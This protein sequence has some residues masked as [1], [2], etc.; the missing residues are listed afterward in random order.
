MKYLYSFKMINS[1]CVSPKIFAATMRK[2]NDGK[3]I[4]NPV[5]KM[6]A[7]TEM[8]SNSRVWT[9]EEQ[10]TQVVFIKQTYQIQI[11]KKLLLLLS[12]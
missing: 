2:K 9:E 3:K 5:T 10:E 6:Y 8:A 4:R 12:S 7:E 11:M 1:T